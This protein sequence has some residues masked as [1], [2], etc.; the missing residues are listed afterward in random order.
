MRPPYEQDVID[1]FE[2]AEAAGVRD[3]DRLLEETRLPHL[4]AAVAALGEIEIA[5]LVLVVAVRRLQ[6]YQKAAN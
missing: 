4:C 6:E 2:V 5:A 3:L 1:S